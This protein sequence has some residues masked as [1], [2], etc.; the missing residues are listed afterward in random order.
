[1]IALLSRHV[2][3]EERDG[4]TSTE[5]I[6]YPQDHREE[7][8]R[9]NTN[10]E[11]ALGELEFYDQILLCLV[12]CRNEETLYRRLPYYGLSWIYQV[13]SLPKVSNALLQDNSMER[14]NALVRLDSITNSIHGVLSRISDE[15][16]ESIDEVSRSYYVQGLILLG[17]HRQAISLV[18]I[19]G[20][21]EICYTHFDLEELS[22]IFTEFLN[23]DEREYYSKIDSK[24][25][26]LITLMKI[27]RLLWRVSDI[28]GLQKSL[29]KCSF[30]ASLNYQLP[31]EMRYGQIYNKDVELLTEKEWQD[32][33]SS[34]IQLLYKMV[35]DRER[36]PS[37]QVYDVTVFSLFV[38]HYASTKEKVLNSIDTAT[39]LKMQSCLQRIANNLL[40]H[41]ERN[42]NAW[43]LM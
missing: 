9:Y 38:L 2:E 4:W 27:E 30:N 7:D 12:M 13:I 17:L 8:E 15:F 33:V 21:F 28:F 6:L 34:C 18:E 16:A 23:E 43:N 26:S 10:E 35:Y 3:L 29:V 11:I 39:F 14:K 42:P 32:N 20:I 22:R 24:G 25:E 40:R 31:P 36:F 5:R 1:M 37:S 41:D 19:P